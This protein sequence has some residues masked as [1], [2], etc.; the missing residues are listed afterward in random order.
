VAAAAILV[1]GVAYADAISDRQALMKKNGAAAGMLFKTAKGEMAFDEAAVM[2]ALETIKDDMSKFG[3]LFPEGSD[4]GETKADPKIW[5]EMADFKGDIANLAA[6]ADKAIAA[7]PKD[8]DALMAVVG[9]IGGACGDC[10]KEYRLPM[11]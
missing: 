7:A 6:L 5:A 2:A 4:K 9:P 10:H 11:N 1:A 8:K 3:D